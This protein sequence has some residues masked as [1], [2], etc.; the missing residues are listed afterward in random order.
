MNRCPARYSVIPSVQ[1]ASSLW[2]HFVPHASPTPGFHPNRFRAASA[3]AGPLNRP[4]VSFRVRRHPSSRREPGAGMS[5]NTWLPALWVKR[6]RSDRGHG[7]TVPTLQPS[8]RAYPRQPMPAYNPVESCRPWILH[9]FRENTSGRH[10]FIL[11]CEPAAHGL[12]GKNTPG[13]QFSCLA[14]PQGFANV[15]AKTKTNGPEVFVNITCPQP[16]SWFN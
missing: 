13:R 16:T 10:L 4:I 15:H 1:R 7:G 9:A 8:G 14:V 11:G 3:T 6:L 2:M 5:P 12:L